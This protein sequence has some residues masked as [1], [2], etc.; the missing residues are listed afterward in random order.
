MARIKTLKQKEK[1]YIFRAFGNEA[2]A[3]PAVCVFKRFPRP[4]E[5]FFAGMKKNLS[6]GLKIDID[7]M[8]ADKEAETKKIGDQIVRVFL[9]N[10]SAGNIDYG[11]FARECISHF[12]EFGDADTGGQIETVNEF[13]ALPEEAVNIIARDCYDYAVTKDEFEMGN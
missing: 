9:D 2:Q 1:R 4:E 13:L 7:K 5:T 12:E 8:R 3:R 11:E 6:D 10:L